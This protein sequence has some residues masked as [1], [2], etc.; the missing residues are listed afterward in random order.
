MQGVEVVE[1]SKID[2]TDIGNN[3]IQIKYD[4]NITSFDENLYQLP[5][6]R[7]VSGVDT[8]AS[9]SLALKVSTIQVD[10]LHT[11]QFFDIKPVM[12][13][14]FVW[15]DYLSTALS[16]L[17]GLLLVALIIY[18]VYRLK[19]QKPIIAIK[20]QPK[21][22]LPPHVEAIQALDAI[23][24]KKL[25]QQGKEKEYY[26]EVSDVVRN[27]IDRRFG[28]NAMEMTSGETLLAVR[29]ISDVDFVFDNLKQMLFVSDMVK[30]AK[31]HPMPEE[32]ELSIGNAYLFVNSTIPVETPPL[33]VP[34]SRD[35]P[36]QSGEGKGVRTKNIE[37]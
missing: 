34:T 3:R 21:V 4:Y 14:D 31:Y 33:P 35:T 19:N 1:I 6:F 23:K 5:P 29:N 28:V 7:V 24:F 15:K 11:D 17:G 8:F 25:W 10:T 13:P 26:S 9:Q 32:N 2:T 20:R 16:I 30:F 12:E 18:L 27:Y 37:I 36:L 22:T